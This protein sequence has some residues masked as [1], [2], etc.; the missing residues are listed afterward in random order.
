M[1]STEGRTMQM[2]KTWRCDA[3]GRE[4]EPQAGLVMWPDL[5]ACSLDAPFEFRLLHRGVCALDPGRF[6]NVRTVAELLGPD[7]L[8]KLTAMLSPGIASPYGVLN[9]PRT[10]QSAPPTDAWVDLFRRL[11]LPGYEQV[12]I[13][14]LQGLRA[15]FSGSDEN[16][17]APYL[18]DGLA[19]F[20]DWCKPRG[21]Q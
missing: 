10:P 11:H 17:V 13:P 16:A 4:V 18:Q 19:A 21:G 1:S 6:T 20:Y 9:N 15:E 3:C 12:R 5:A 14:Y 7:G 2:C 8:A